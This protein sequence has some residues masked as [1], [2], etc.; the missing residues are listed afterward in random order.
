MLSPRNLKELGPDLSQRKNFVGEQSG[1]SVQTVAKQ[2]TNLQKEGLT[3]NT[4]GMNCEYVPIVAKQGGG[5]L[6]EGGLKPRR[7]Q[8]RMEKIGTNS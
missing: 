2:G 1:K 5:E 4:I 7:C 3:K 6:A 8:M